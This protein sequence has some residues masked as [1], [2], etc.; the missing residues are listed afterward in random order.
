MAIQLSF[1]SDS[2]E[3]LKEGV[4][5][6]GKILRSTLGPRGRAVVI[7]QGWG[8]PE[9]T[10]DGNDVADEIE[11]ENA[12]ENIG[13]RMVREAAKKTNKE[14]GDGTTTSAVLAESIFLNGL[15][16][17]V[18]GANPM[19]LRKG[20]EKAASI[21]SDYV[22]DLSRDVEGNDEVRR[23]ASLASKNDDEVGDLIAE[24][25]DEVG[26]NGAI[27]VE[28]GKGRESDLWVVK[29]MQFDRG[30]LSS[31]FVT[32]EESGECQLENPYILLYEDKIT[33]ASD[34]IP[35]LEKLTN[36]NRPLLVI[37]EKVE[38]DALATMVVNKK[39]GILDCAA[40]KAPGYGERRTSMLGDIA[41]LTD[42]TPIYEDLGLSVSDVAI[43]QLGEA[44]KVTIDSERTTISGG[45]GSK[46]QIRQRI[47]EISQ[48]LETTDSS[49]DREKLEERR[50][51]LSSGLAE[52]RVGASSEAELKEKKSRTKDALSAVRSAL[53][54]GVVPGGG[55]ALIRALEAFEDTDVTFEGDEALAEK[56]FKDA[57][58]KPIK[59]IADNAGFD[60]ERTS[61]RVQDESGSF[62]FDVTRGEFGDLEEFSVLD[63]AKVVRTAVENAA[64]VAG[65][66]LTTNCLIS[67][68]T[69]PEQEEGEEEEEERSDEE[70]AEEA[71]YV[72]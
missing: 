60:P 70:V 38:E 63:S 55:V 56:I 32:D 33:E 7:D 37:A 54:Q 52:V 50:A 59:Q 28:E 11:L 71:G 41:A 67:E 20:F 6:A 31:E 51:R 62:G 25:F 46:K 29:G 9:I 24:A 18:A 13:A 14:A 10:A 2:R 40:I 36:E 17:V 21:V 42:A 44:E 34:I 4:S 8:S 47:N 39:R 15:K 5:K 66:L 45:A 35:F 68:F 53:D 48:E 72:R 43:H 58:T 19:A 61:K 12:Y 64:S 22:E 3:F 23:L 16:Q 1:D 26:E 49:Y 27:S 30:Y 69:E 65:V 57:L